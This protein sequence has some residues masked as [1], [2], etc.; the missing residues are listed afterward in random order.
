MSWSAGSG[1]GLTP[2]VP[3]PRRVA[4][5]P[6]PARPRALRA[7]RRVLELPQSR[8]LE[9]AVR[10]ITGQAAKTNDLIVEAMDAGLTPDR[11]VTI[12]AKMLRPELL[13]TKAE[14]ERPVDC[15]T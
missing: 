1:L 3:L 4:P 13:R 9:R 6:H 8:T 5:R 15:S 7:D 11:L 12:A 10:S 14:P 2:S